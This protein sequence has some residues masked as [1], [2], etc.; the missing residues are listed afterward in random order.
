V[1]ISSVAL[2]LEA[3]L[4]HLQL[5]ILY[6]LLIMSTAPQLMKL[7]FDIWHYCHFRDV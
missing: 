5:M 6:T 3:S 7:I 1:T 2:P 4:R